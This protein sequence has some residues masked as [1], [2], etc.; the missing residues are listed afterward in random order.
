MNE[1]SR[2]ELEAWATLHQN[3]RRPRESRPTTVAG[4]S[5]D[6]WCQYSREI[7]TPVRGC[8][9]TDV[10]RGVDMHRS[11]HQQ[12]GWGHS[13]A[14]ALATPAGDSGAAW[15]QRAART[16]PL[17]SGVKYSSGF[18][19]P[20]GGANNRSNY[21]DGPR[22]DGGDKQT[23]PRHQYLSGCNTDQ[24]EHA[25]GHQQRQNQH[26]RSDISVRCVALH[27]CMHRSTTAAQLGGTTCMY[28]RSIGAAAP[29][30]TLLGVRTFTDLF[31]QA[32]PGAC[33]EGHEGG[34]SFPKAAQG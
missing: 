2:A 22:S 18:R 13:T 27:S 5:T 1:I 28:A 11:N 20:A 12:F 29:P 33:E 3:T 34:E 10:P 24:E 31:V 17:P 19:G 25:A 16:T 15:Y 7:D 30:R 6:Y 4:P 14:V 21:H 32:P 23:L 26:D 9:A 8:T